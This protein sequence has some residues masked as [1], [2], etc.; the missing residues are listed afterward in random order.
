MTAC[1][2]S[3]LYVSAYQFAGTAAY[4]Q[5][6]DAS[7]SAMAKQMGVQNLGATLSLP[8]STGDLS[9]VSNISAYVSG[10]YTKSQLQASQSSFSKLTSSDTDVSSVSTAQAYASYGYLAA[11]LG[12]ATPLQTTS[13]DTVMKA[14]TAVK[15]SPSNYVQTLLQSTPS[16]AMQVYANSL[17]SYFPG[18]YVSTAA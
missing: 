13:M 14:A 1:D 10:L 18:V 8:D 6:A 2:I 9:T 12:L 11:K 17:S 4:Q 15:T 3:A 5:N 7:A 16:A